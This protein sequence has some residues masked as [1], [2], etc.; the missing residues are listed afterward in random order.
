MMQAQKL[1]TAALKKIKSFWWLSRRECS[2]LSSCDK[3]Q[4]TTKTLSLCHTFTQT[5]QDREQSEHPNILSHL[6]RHT[7][8]P[9]ALSCYVKSSQNISLFFPCCTLSPT[10]LSWLDVVTVVWGFSELYSILRS[11]QDSWIMEIIFVPKS[12]CQLNEMQH[13]GKDA[14]ATRPVSPDP[15]HLLRDTIQT[16][17]T[18]TTAALRLGT[19][20]T[21]LCVRSPSSLSA[22][23]CFH[24]SG[25]F[26]FWCPYLL[27]SSYISTRWSGLIVTISAFNSLRKSPQV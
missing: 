23:A 14:W 16:L 13:P 3:L 1:H 4:S 21:Y 6:H 26:Y 22:A 15:H 7:E 19:K 11:R 9:W 18:S 24:R 17:H 8:Q 20:Y 2:F 5:Q 12:L 27:L 10:F 25:F